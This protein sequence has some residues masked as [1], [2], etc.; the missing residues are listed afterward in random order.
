MATPCSFRNLLL[1]KYSCT[2]SICHFNTLQ[3]IYVEDWHTDRH[4]LSPNN[5]NSVQKKQ[6]QMQR[7]GC[8]RDIDNISKW[9]RMIKISLQ[10]SSNKFNQILRLNACNLFC[11]HLSFPPLLPKVPLWAM[12][13]WRFLYLSVLTEY[14]STVTY[15]IFFYKAYSTWL[16]TL[17]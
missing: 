3:Q 17:H 5:T 7:S 9:K 2:E 11:N 13:T 6:I 1:T 12:L 15:R 14:R 8:I 16:T 10:K 4:I